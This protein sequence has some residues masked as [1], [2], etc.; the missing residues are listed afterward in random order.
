MSWSTPAHLPGSA[1]PSATLNRDLDNIEALYEGFDVYLGGADDDLNI[2]VGSLR[3]GALL[4]PV[5]S[6]S[7][8]TVANIG[9][10]SDT[11][12]GHVDLGVFI[13]DGDDKSCTQL[14]TTGFFPMPGGAGPK[15]ETLSAAVQLEPLQK[16][17]LAIAFDASGAALRGTDGPYA[18]LCR[19]ATGGNTVSYYPLPTR[20]P[21]DVNA[22]TGEPIAL[23]K[24]PCLA[25][26]S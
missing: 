13:D 16:Y 7:R 10:R 22:T 19:K 23:T 17:W 21:F 6:K 4:I 9:Y 18:T 25:V 12:G 20:I 3:Y 26:W 1:L 14:E 24:A 15:G 11:A 2:N 5:I 8:F